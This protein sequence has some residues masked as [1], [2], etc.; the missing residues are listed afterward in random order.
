MKLGLFLPTFRHWLDIPALRELVTLCEDR[1]LDSVWLPDRMAFPAGQDDSALVRPMSTWLKSD[2]EE[3]H[4]GQHGGGYRADE[5]VGEWFRDVYVMA[6]AIAG[7]TAKLEIGTSIALVPHR[8]PFVTARSIATLDQLTGGRFRWGVGT[9]HVKGEYELLRADYADRHDML[10]EWLDC[11]VAL[12]TQDPAEFHGRF[13]DFDAV[14]MLLEPTTKPHPP[15]LIGGNGK[16]ALRLAARLGGG[17]VPAYLRPDELRTG[18]DFIREE[19]AQSGLVGD[20]T[21][22]LLSRFRMVGSPQETP[23][24]SRPLY[25]VDML[26]QLLQEFAEA[27]CES[28]VAHV[29]TKDASVMK[30]QIELLAEAASLSRQHVASP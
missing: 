8:N 20:P 27:G 2:L 12:W 7:M 17:W 26:A 5:R 25:T 13:W 30:D 1:G 19:M 24:N 18:V 16:R 22:V 11:M 28:L 15:I 29:P 10:A 9:G 23:P 4:W 14:R 6:G 21:P 3:N